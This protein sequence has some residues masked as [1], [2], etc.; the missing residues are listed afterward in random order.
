M[1]IEQWP[2]E[3]LSWLQNLRNLLQRQ[4]WRLQDLRDSGGLAIHFF[5]V[6]LNQLLSASLPQDSHPALYI[7]TFRVITSD[8][9][10]YRHSLGTQKSFLMQLHPTQGIVH[11]FDLPTYITDELLSLLERFLEG[12]TGPHHDIKSA[13]QQLSLPVNRPKARSSVPRHCELSPGSRSHP[14]CDPGALVI[15]LLHHIS[16]SHNYVETPLV[17]L[18]L[19]SLPFQA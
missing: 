17:F 14:P 7:T 12:H 9:S 13:V 5:L 2:P 1:Y 10:E 4:L 19:D 3:F 15:P 8:W 6:T 16:P 18:S 11:R